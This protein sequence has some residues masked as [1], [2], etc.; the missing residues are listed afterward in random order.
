MND[1]LYIVIPAYNEE[2]TIENVVTEW[3]EIVGKIGNNSK[4]VVINDGSKDSTMD[5]LEELSKKFTCLIVLNK[6]NGGHGDT[7]LYGYKYAIDNNADYIFQTDSDGQTLPSEF[8][9]FWN[10]RNKFS[11]IIGHREGRQDGFSRIVVTKTLK[12][13]L[14]MIFHLNITDANTP[15][16]LM[17]REVVEKYYPQIPE[18]FNLSN[19]LLTVLL[20]KNKESVEFKKITFRPRQGGVNSINLKKISKIGMKAVKDFRYLRKCLNKM[21]EEYNCLAY[22]GKERN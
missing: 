1:N 19:V 8:W 17:K 18:H 10:E 4:L 5:K 16:R 11:A 9:N 20:M 7:V 3:H 12:L 21:G 13:V 6:E 15:F 14:F 2:E 22:S